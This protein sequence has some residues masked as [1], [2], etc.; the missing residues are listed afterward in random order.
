MSERVCIR[1]LSLFQRFPFA[2]F[3][4]HGM[5][6]DMGYAGLIAAATLRIKKS[7]SNIEENGIR[8][9]N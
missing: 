3:Y 2:L 7:N 6:R 4:M 5:L 9:N 8:W 1:L